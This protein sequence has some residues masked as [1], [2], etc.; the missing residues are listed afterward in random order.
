MEMMED[1]KQ[2]FR[3]IL[4]AFLDKHQFYLPTLVRESAAAAPPA[5]VVLSADTAANHS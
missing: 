5:N 3:D 4:T 1:N 2:L